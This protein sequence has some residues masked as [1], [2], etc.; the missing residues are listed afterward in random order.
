MF[1]RFFAVQFL[2]FGLYFSADS[3][4]I[5]S[6]DL[7][8]SGNYSN[9][10]SDGTGNFERSFLSG[11][12]IGIGAESTVLP[13]LSVVTSLEFSSRRYEHV[14]EFRNLEGTNNLLHLSLPVLAK[15]EGP[16]RFSDLFMKIGPRFDFLLSSNLE[17][18]MFCSVVECFQVTDRIEPERSKT[19]VPGWSAALG[20]SL[21][22][23]SK[24][25][26]IE[27]RYN[28]DFTNLLKDERSESIQKRSFDI[29]LRIPFR[30][31][32]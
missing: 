17:W 27:F 4:I 7:T 28:D 14:F 26:D 12:G 10:I 18:V 24:E 21:T 1:K 31:F 13:K 9:L 2:L 3:Q 30:T 32:F 23:F 6:F 16:G 5:N 15:I 29:W 8:V 20:S 19:M 22:V 11:Y 25:V